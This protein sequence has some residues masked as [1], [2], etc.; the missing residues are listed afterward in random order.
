[1][2]LSYSGGGLP[3]VGACSSEKKTNWLVLHRCRNGAIPPKIL[4]RGAEPPFVLQTSIVIA[5]ISKHLPGL[6]MSKC[7]SIAAKSIPLDL[8]FMFSPR[9]SPRSCKNG[10]GLTQVGVVV[11]ISR[12]QLDIQL[13]QPSIF[14]YAYVL[15][16]G[17]HCS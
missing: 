14:S 12:A 5:Q 1:M 8:Q 16:H 9:N 17:C 11:K 7:A 6:I 3:E 10:R 15:V 13:P 4:G 2:K